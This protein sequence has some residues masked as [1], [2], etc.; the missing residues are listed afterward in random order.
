PRNRSD[1]SQPCTA[2]TKN[3]SRK[4]T[5]R[6]QRQNS[7]S[8]CSLRSLAATDQRAPCF[9][10]CEPN[11]TALLWSAA[12]A[13]SE[14]P[15]AN[16]SGCK[17]SPSLFRERWLGSTPGRRESGATSAWRFDFG[18]GNAPPAPRLCANS[19]QSDDGKT[20]RTFRITA[21]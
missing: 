1:I 3:S 21:L 19:T 16:L 18:S 10:H 13:S 17:A 5:Q 2:S 20:E 14:S 12:D 15:G 11:R 6:S 7:F 9:L 8:L 4:R